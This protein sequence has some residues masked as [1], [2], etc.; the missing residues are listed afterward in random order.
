GR[1]SQA[2]GSDPGRATAVADRERAS[3]AGGAGAPRRP[4]QEPGKERQAPVHPAGPELAQRQAQQARSPDHSGRRR[5]VPQGLTA[6]LS[7]TSFS[8]R[9]AFGRSFGVP[10]VLSISLFLSRPA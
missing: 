1:S 2:E 3:E 8:V 7:P 5:P 10:R 9:K 4:A 6:G